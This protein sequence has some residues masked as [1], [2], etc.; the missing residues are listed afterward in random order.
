[1]AISAGAASISNDLSKRKVI[2]N[3]QDI[4][5]FLCIIPSALSQLSDLF[6][7]PMIVCDSNFEIISINRNCI[8]LLGIDPEKTTAKNFKNFFTSEEDKSV[9][10][11]IIRGLQKDGTWNGKIKNCSAGKK[12][13]IVDVYAIIL[14]NGKNKKIIFCFSPE[15]NKLNISC[16]INKIELLTSVLLSFSKGSLYFYNPKSKDIT[17]LGS[18]LEEQLGYEKNILQNNTEIL[19]TLV[20]KSDRNE[21]VKKFKEYEI[22]KVRNSFRHE[23][24]LKC[25]NQEWETFTN[26]F[27]TI[28]IEYQSGKNFVFGYFEKTEKPKIKDNLEPETENYKTLLSDKKKI[29]E[30]FIEQKELY[31]SLVESSFDAV[32]ISRGRR[33]LL[34]NGAWLK[35]FGYTEEEIYNTSFDIIKIVAPSDRPRIFEK[36]EKN[37]KEYSRYEMQGITKNGDVID[38]DVSVRMIKWKGSVVY[39]GIYKNVSEKKYSEIINERKDKLFENVA[40]ATRQF[41]IQPDIDKAVYNALNIIGNAAGLS[42]IYVFENYD[43]KNTNEHFMRRKYEWIDGKVSSKINNDEIQTLSYKKFLGWYS[44]LS[45]GMVIK[46]VLDEF[47]DTI[48]EIYQADKTRSILITPIIVNHKFC[49]FIGCDDCKNARIWNKAEV[50]AFVTIANVIGNTFS[51]SITEQ[52][53]KESEERY[54]FLFDQAADLIITLDAELNVNSINKKIESN[55]GWEQEE[56]IGRNIL[57]S[58]F[59]TSDSRKE[60]FNNIGAINEEAFFEVEINK[61]DGSIIPC[62]INAVPIYDGDELINIQLVL[63]NIKERKENERYLRESEEKYRNI[64]ENI[65]DI[66]FQTDIHGKIT[67]ISP[68][69]ERYSGYKPDELVGKKVINFYATPRDRAKLTKEMQEKN[70]VSDFII[71]LRNKESKMVYVSV[72][73]HSLRNKYG[74]I[75]GVEGSLRD[76]TEREIAYDEIRKLS[77]A[78]EQSASTVMI[79]DILGKI[80]YVNPKFTVSTGYHPIEVMGKSSNIL[81]SGEMNFEQYSDLWKTI[82]AGKE[83]KGEFHNK[84]KNGELFWESASL[85][86]IKN[87]TGEITHYLAVK[88]DITEKKNQERKLLRYQTLLKGVAESVQL[89]ISEKDFAHGI[90]NALAALGKGSSADR[91]YIFESCNTNTKNDSFMNLKYEWHSDKI[92]QSIDSNYINSFSGDGSISSILQNIGKNKTCHVL[93]RQL[94]GDDQVY[95]NRYGTLSILI[96]PIYVEKIFWGFIGFD[97][98]QGE[99]KWSESEESILTAAAAS[100]GRAIEREKTNMELI[101]AKEEAEKAERL[102]SEFLAQISHEI[103]SPLNVLLNYSQLFKQ[104]IGD[105]IEP[106]IFQGFDGME[107]AGNRIIRTIDLLLNISEL[108]TGSYSFRPKTID[109][110]SQVVSPLFNE[111]KKLA[112]GKNLILNTI[113]HTD[114]T[115]LNCDEYSVTQIFANL[116]DNAIKYTNEGKIEIFIDR[117]FS[118]K[119][120]VKVADSGIGISE[121]Y[122]P[123]L[124]S[125]FSQ[126]E[127]GYT[128]SYEGNGLGLALVKK[129]CEINNIDIYVDSIKNKGTTFTLIFN[130]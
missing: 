21:L 14:K 5:P 85:S 38:I 104:L 94:T 102:K 46:G 77:Q 120:F 127:Q 39:Q 114:N 26:Y 101:R 7:L 45:T 97:N 34:V 100:I 115:K 28:Q 92:S 62:E 70:E 129:Y 43:D 25:N 57:H 10:D 9:E 11:K 36:F 67:T 86:P 12:K 108:Q 111:Y 48:R 126:E 128:R 68:S 79:T 99:E 15:K 69:I 63:K 72:N 37:T 55:T 33:L 27:A 89:L 19:N 59:L 71:R 66:F 78:V 47:P 56:L 82:T 58:E 110:Y 60:F 123:Q 30:V 31:N 103:R 35:M 109:I 20:N 24:R 107:N 122:L 125:Q 8:K 106:E 6:D 81:K 52:L 116:I 22:S 16:I 32:F 118:N 51:R 75:I 64:F 88:E 73:S 44:Q 1:L 13:I 130:S 54:K 113:R 121:N 91:V 18:N 17:L 2:D 3:S 124:Y 95:L 49:G 83:W 4:H 119:L 50:S 87:E 74:E 105:N 96:V 112:R 42:K 41:L 40:E 53:L 65:Q 61:K 93:T 76:V 84:K 23:I 90:N 117:N 98:C 80:V 29:E